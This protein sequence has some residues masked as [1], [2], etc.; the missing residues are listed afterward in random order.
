LSLFYQN[1]TKHIFT[2]EKQGTVV[3]F[4]SVMTAPTDLPDA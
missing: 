2:N 1:C 3:T 4:S